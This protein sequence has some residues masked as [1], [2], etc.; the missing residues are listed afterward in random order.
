MLW[1]KEESF[2]FF[3]YSAYFTLAEHNLRQI[4]IVQNCP[5]KSAFNAS[6]RN[7]LA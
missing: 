5:R 6:V 3:V 7:G 4:S 2:A 1:S